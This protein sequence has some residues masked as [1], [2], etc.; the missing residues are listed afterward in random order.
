MLK[1][2]TVLV[3]TTLFILAASKGSGQTSDSLLDKMASLEAVTRRL[4][5]AIQDQ[6]Q[7]LDSLEQE[8]QEAR[9]GL[10][11]SFVKVVQGTAIKPTRSGSNQAGATCDEGYVAIGGSCAGNPLNVIHPMTAIDGR[12]FWCI[13]HLGAQD[14]ERTL[15]ADAACM[16][17]HP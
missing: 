4:E 11:R 12:T 3:I 13:F 15:R 2:G 7:K 17:M 9:A 5:A 6:K 16:K 8:V 14:Q 1:S 10:P